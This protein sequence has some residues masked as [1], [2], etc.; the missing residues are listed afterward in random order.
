MKIKICGITR[1]EDVYKCEESGANLIGFINIK[2]S[3]RFVTLKEIKTLVSS[4]KD[5]N[6]AVLVLEPDNPEEVVMKMK[7]TGIRIVQL[8]SLSDNEIK[9]LKWIEGFKR[10]LL[11]RNITVIRAIGLS[12]ESLEMKDEELKFS[13]SKIKEIENFAKICDGLL[14]DYKVNGKT[15]GT[16]LQIPTDMVLGAVKI[17]KNVNHDIKIFLAGGINSER[18][19]NDKELLEN[20]LDYFDVNS[21]VEDR[22]GIKNPELVDELM[23]IK[24]QI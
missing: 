2:R 23:E 8:H 1:F 19:K 17:A 7:K 20:V 10:T 24:A 22:P 3:K 4:M 13:I 12:N 5:K 9:Y 16:G 18:I 15:G 11:E 14:F 21:G 6:R